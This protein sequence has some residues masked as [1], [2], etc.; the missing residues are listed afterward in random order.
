MLRG[1]SDYTWYSLQNFS[2]IHSLGWYVLLIIILI[3]ADVKV[4]FII[5]SNY[6]DIN[7]NQKGSTRWST[8][9]EIRDQYPTI[10]L[11]FKYPYETYFGKGGVPVCQYGTYYNEQQE[12]CDIDKGIIFIDRTPVNNLVI[13]ITRS[14]KGEMFVFLII[15][16]YSRAE[17][18]V[19]YLN[20]S[21]DGELK[22]YASNIY[23]DYRAG[24]IRKTD[25]PSQISEK[26]L[27]FGKK[28]F[29]QVIH[30]Y[31]KETNIKQNTVFLITFK[32]I[33]KGTLL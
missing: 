3:V 27:N 32:M 13:G 17:N 14:G 26:Q 16:I 7:K 20:Y 15:D 21:E 30:N 4:F 18:K 8:L 9:D 2:P 33:R 22:M 19:Y 29:Y 23:Y 28:E 24:G 10:P 6:R 1:E 5:Y 31:E 11:K 12:L 25:I